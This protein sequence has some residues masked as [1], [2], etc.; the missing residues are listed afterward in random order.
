ME[1]R[2]CLSRDNTAP[3]VDSTEYRRL[4]GNLRYLLHTRPD[5]AFAVGFASRFMERLTEEHMKAVKRILRYINGTLDYGLRYE[6]LIETTRTTSKQQIGASN[7]R[8]ASKG[9]SQITERESR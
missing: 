9:T 8:Q 2:L 6:K 4:V 1:E 3:E 7:L 5:L